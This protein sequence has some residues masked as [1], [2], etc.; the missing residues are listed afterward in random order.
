MSKIAISIALLP[1]D[2]IMDMAISINKNYPDDPIQLNKEN[3]LPHISLCLGVVEEEQLPEIRN[4]ITEI[5]Q[6][7][8]PL[9][10]TI[11]QIRDYHSSLELLP[12]E[13]LQQLHEGIITRLEPYLSYNASTDMFFTPPAVV[14]KSLFRVQIYRE[15]SSFASYYPHITLL[16]G[17]K[18]TNQDIQK[19]FI[20]S[21]IAICQLGN[22]C[23]CRKILYTTDLK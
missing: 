10:L 2:D 6:D 12:D 22:Y 7:I 15:K 19:N 3:C 14:E 23:T 9:S 13:K 21:R 4:I 17:T 20:A 1:P 5:T 11:S 8:S 18:L 16:A